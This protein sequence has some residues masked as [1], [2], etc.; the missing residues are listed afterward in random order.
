MNA[1]YMY[2]STPLHLSILY[3]YYLSESQ[4]PYTRIYDEICEGWISVS[5]Y[6]PIH[7]ATNPRQYSIFRNPLCAHKWTLANFKKAE[8]EEDSLEYLTDYFYDLHEVNSYLRHKRDQDLESRGIVE[9][10]EEGEEG[11]SSSSPAS[12]NDIRNDI[13]NENEANIVFVDGTTCYRG[14]VERCNN[15]NSDGSSS[16]SASSSSSSSS[17]KKRESGISRGREPS[18]LT[19]NYEEREREERVEL[20]LD[21]VREE[22]QGIKENTEAANIQWEESV[23][24]SDMQTV[25][26]L[27]DPDQGQEEEEQEKEGVGEVPEVNLLDP[28]QGQEEQEGEHEQEEEVQEVIAADVEVMESAASAAAVVNAVTDSEKDKRAEGAEIEIEA[29][30]ET[31]AAAL[32]LAQRRGAKRSSRGLVSSHITSYYPLLLCRCDHIFLLINLIRS[33]PTLSEHVMI[34]LAACASIWLH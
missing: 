33:I 2:D 18:I 23:C 6:D 20:M 32:G 1:F 15:N 4:F 34:A 10:E 28:D 9:E 27:L 21:Q 12:A 8:G 22:C 29:E 5:I 3:T 24:N 13:R 30:M 31:D 17:S 19:N 25:M 14:G 26:N 7:L 16:D 11:E